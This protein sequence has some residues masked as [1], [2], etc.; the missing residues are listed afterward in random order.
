MAV[1][2]AVH[3]RASL[4]NAIN[5][6]TK[7]E[8][9]DD[10]LITGKDC[11]PFNAIDDMKATKELFGKTGG[12]QY[13]HYVQSF[14]EKENVTPQQ[15]HEIACKWAEKEFKGHECLISTHVDKGHIHSHV[16][17]N[18]VNFENGKKLHTSAKWLDQAKEHSDELCREYGL[19]ITEKGRT[20]DGEKR[21]ELTSFDK[22]KYNLLLKA[23]AGKIKSYVLD[24][25]RAVLECKKKSISKDDFI[26]NMKEKGYKTTWN[27]K[28][29][30]ITFE[31]ADGKKVRASNIE[32]TFH[33]HV[34]KVSLLERFA[35]NLDS[36]LS[37]TKSKGKELKNKL[38]NTIWIGAGKN[39]RALEE[40]IETLKERVKGLNSLKIELESEINEIHG[41]DTN[42]A[43][44]EQIT[45]ILKEYADDDYVENMLK[46]IDNSIMH[47][48]FREVP[49]LKAIPKKNND[50][51]VR[52]KKPIVKTP[53]KKKE[54]LIEGM[55]YDKGVY[56]GISKNMHIFLKNNE[57]RL[58]QN[59]E[60]KG[61]ANTENDIRNL[62]TQL[63][64]KNKF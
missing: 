11:N 58:Y 45:M 17:V 40:Q 55:K 27:E 7:K 30:H 8:K 47:S 37:E 34:D 20:F 57:Y 5:Y 60:L 39:K 19:T 46:D 50:M 14:H 42:K 61:T 25:A 53:E 6:I 54:I 32:N 21:T 24:T 23:K 10:K 56:V 43:E 62:A 4:G 13:D 16:I 28:R 52:P 64:K 12:R 2:K 44:K 18:T 3:S 49:E 15:A 22:D 36:E 1:L 51:A 9:T 59:N 48:Q 41:K 26:K 31:N 63:D 29:N 35:K 33:V 38:E